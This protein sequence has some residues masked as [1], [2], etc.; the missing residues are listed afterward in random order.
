MNTPPG[1]Q[2]PP[3]DG[4]IAQEGNQSAPT[5]S[6]ELRG[7]LVA[8][9]REL[10]G[11]LAITRYLTTA[12]ANALLRPGRDESVGR[13]RLFALAGLT[14]RR[15]ANRVHRKLPAPVFS[16]PYVRRLLFR[17]TAGQRVDVWALTPHGYALAEQTLG[18]ERKVHREDVS[19]MFLEHWV[20]LTDLFVGL[21]G[22]LLV[23]GVKVRDLPFHW[24]PS[25]STHLPWKEYD[26]DNNVVR[27]RVIV[28]DAVLEL[29]GLKRR[30]FIECEMGTHSIVSSS[31]EKAGATLRKTERYDEFFG[32]YADPAAK[33]TF[34]AQAFPDRWPAEVLYLVRKDSRRNSVNAALARW[35]TGRAG[36]AVQARAATVADAIREIG[37]LLGPV[38][39]QPPN[40]PPGIHLS[41][42]EVKLLRK[43]YQHALMQ[44][45]TSG[46]ELPGPLREAA[47]RVRAVLTR[48]S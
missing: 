25:D 29:P 33:V 24:D 7:K 2:S 6:T 30:Y 41:P 1:T 19:E 5:P 21:T 37:A 11:L 32:G 16:P 48:T 44:L 10:V 35:R 28:P 20:T 22:P 42:D 46:R 43:F 36:L 9:D 39:P 23:R 45:G 18:Q 4:A 15:Q 12:Q 14:P 8:R 26:A 40:E 47:L 31:D 34:Y 38:G 13:Q 17:S 27:P 3:G